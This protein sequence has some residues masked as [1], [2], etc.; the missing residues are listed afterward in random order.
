M[1]LHQQHLIKLFKYS[2]LCWVLQFQSLGAIFFFVCFLLI[3]VH[4]TSAYYHFK[5]NFV[6]MCKT[7]TARILKK[8]L[9]RW[10]YI[11]QWYLLKWV[12]TR[13][14][15]TWVFWRD[16]VNYGSA[17]TWTLLLPVWKAFTSTQN[18]IYAL[19]TSRNPLQ[20]CLVFHL[21]LNL[22]LKTS[23]WANFYSSHYIILS[24]LVKSSV[25]RNINRTAEKRLGPVQE[26]LPSFTKVTWEMNQ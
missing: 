13:R 11:F 7:F 22:L 15:R 20:S 14:E 8:F 19:D 2:K 4:W 26:K 23:L 18:Q 25:P 1:D 3:I 16:T 5:G 12:S 17:L 9:H 24:Y 21:I 10:Q 6:N